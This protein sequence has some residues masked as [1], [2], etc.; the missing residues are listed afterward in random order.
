MKKITSLILS[1]LLMLSL[2]PAAL[3]EEPAVTVTPSVTEG[4]ASIEGDTIL[5]IE[6]TAA[7]IAFTPDP[8]LDIIGYQY[9]SRMPEGADITDATPFEGD[10]LIPTYTFG[11]L[12]AGTYFF[13]LNITKN[14]DD[15]QGQGD[16]PTVFTKEYTVQVIAL[17]QNLTLTPDVQSGSASISGEDVYKRQ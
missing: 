10:Y 16:Y 6:G 7:T 12:S 3:A 5:L 8:D 4:T 13:E 2:I 1:A 9:G 15:P 11:A 14:P 17:P